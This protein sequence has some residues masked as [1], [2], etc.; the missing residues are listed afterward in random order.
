MCLQP[1][2]SVIFWYVMILS[3]CS[4]ETPPGVLHLALRS[5]VQDRNGPVKTGTE[6]GYK[7]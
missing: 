1:K 6:E 7:K 4:A 3:L 2:K 5:P